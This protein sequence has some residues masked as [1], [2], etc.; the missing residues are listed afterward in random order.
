[1]S[2]RPKPRRATR[3]AIAITTLALLPWLPASGRPGTAPAAPLDLSTAQTS[4]WMVQLRE[5][6]LAAYRGGYH[7]LAATSPVATGQRTLD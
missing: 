5:P 4:R 6:S 3:A 2:A 7:G 1:M